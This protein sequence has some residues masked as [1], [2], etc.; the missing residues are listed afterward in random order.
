[1]GFKFC[2]ILVLPALLKRI[3]SVMSGKL[4]VPSGGKVVLKVFSS[5]H[6]WILVVKDNCLL[7]IFRD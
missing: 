5:K 6:R 3:K 4:L 2:R 7:T 1:M